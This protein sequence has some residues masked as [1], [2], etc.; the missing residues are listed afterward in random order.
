[1]TERPAR[2]LLRFDD[3][4]PAM[5][6][7]AWERFEQMVCEFRIRPILAIVPENQ[8]PDLVRDAGDENF[9][10][11]MRSLQALGATI[12]LHGYRHLCV[13]DGRS[14]LPLHRLTEFAGVPAATQSAWI[15]TGV[16]ILREHGLEPKLFVAPRHGLDHG[17]LLALRAAGIA[18]ISDGF[19]RM[20][21]LHQ[22]IAW[23]PQQLWGPV[24]KKSGIWTICVHSNHATDEQA[25][26]VAEFLSAH[27]AMFMDAEEA[28]RV[29]KP[30]RAGVSAQTWMTAQ[31]WRMRLKRIARRQTQSAVV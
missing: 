4:C 30:S 18:A 25:R 26:S 1:M 16:R 19:G 14:L 27:H 9:W 10:E 29:A 15:E 12:A 31:Y 23:I 8:D 20:P 22:G 17:T 2:Y 5:D 3:L 13:S 6:R 24:R 11:R 7:N 21:T 28:I